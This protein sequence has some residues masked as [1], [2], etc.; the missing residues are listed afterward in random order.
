MKTF[1]MQRID[2]FKESEQASSLKMRDYKDSTDL[3]LRGGVRDN[4]RC[5]RILGI[6]WT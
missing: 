5:L 6:V 4:K 2:E 1:A 3:I